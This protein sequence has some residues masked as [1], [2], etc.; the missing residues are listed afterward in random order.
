MRPDLKKEKN[1]KANINNSLYSE[2]GIFKSSDNSVAL[3]ES[4]CYRICYDTV[5][6]QSTQ[7]VW[8]MLTNTTHDALLLRTFTDSGLE[9]TH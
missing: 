3:N 6:F 8:Y 5:Y 4:A 2:H 7:N 9:T 1:E